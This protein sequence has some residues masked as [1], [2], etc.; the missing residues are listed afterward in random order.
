MTWL[1]DKGMNGG[2]MRPE[3]SR[4]IFKAHIVP[5]VTYG[6]Q[7]GLIDKEHIKGME[8][9][10]YSSLRQM[11]FVRRTTSNDALHVL[12]GMESMEERNQVLFMRHVQKVT[13]S[14]R[15]ET[16]VGKMTTAII[17]DGVGNYDR[18]DKSIYNDIVNRSK[19]GQEIL[20]QEYPTWKKVR[21]DKIQELEK[22]RVNGGLTARN[23]PRVIRWRCHPI[24]GE[25]QELSRPAIKAISQWMCGSIPNHTPCFKCI[26]RTVVNKEH[27]MECSGIKNWLV[28][29][30]KREKWNQRKIEEIDVLEG[31]E[32]E[33]EGIRDNACLLDKVINFI[34]ET[35]PIKW[36]ILEEIGMEIHRRIKG[37]LLKIG[38]EENTY[39]GDN[40]ISEDYKAKVK[41]AKDNKNYKEKRKREKAKDKERKKRK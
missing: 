39:A 19:Y 1:H 35:K 2:E 22:K 37:D 23:L 5:K 41:K 40:D 17:K 29:L 25:S 27:A 13:Q 18:R 6:M 33:E 4:R 14:D 32:V 36:K 16:L 26:G 12:N 8:D 28:D 7:L 10:Q 20:L 34:C 38:K 15:K 11:T 3:G 9:L 24:I 31:Y 30:I 21:E